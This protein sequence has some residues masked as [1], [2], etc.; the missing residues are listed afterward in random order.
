MAG[1]NLEPLAFAKIGVLGFR[2]RDRFP[3]QI[4]QE[5]A[6]KQLPRVAVDHEVMKRAQQ[7]V[8][9]GIHLDKLEPKQR[10]LRQIK[11]D[12]AELPRKFF[13]GGGCPEIELA[14]GT[15]NRTRREDPL[16][17]RSGGGLEYGT[18]PIVTPD[19]PRER[20]PHPG[21]VKRPA[22][23]ERPQ[24]IE[25]RAIPRDFAGAPKR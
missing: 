8:F 5:L 10:A 24:K 19:N 18:Q 15:V 7:V 1:A 14:A 12:Q 4:S 20:E 11:W 17:Q 16:P 2:M 9:A 13:R 23:S 21:R 3:G 6:D 25:A 22:K